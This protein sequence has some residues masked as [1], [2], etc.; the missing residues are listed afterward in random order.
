MESDTNTSSTIEEGA[1]EWPATGFES[2]GGSQGQGFDSFTLL[3]PS[4]D[5]GSRRLR[6]GEPNPLAGTKFQSA[7]VAQQV[8]RPVEAGK[9]VRSIRT[10]STKS[11]DRGVQRQHVSL[12]SLGC[13]FDSRRSLQVVRSS[14]AQLA[15]ATDRDSVQWEFESPR[16]YQ[17]DGGSNPPGRS[18]SSGSSSVSEASMT[19]YVP[20]VLG[21]Q[22]L[23]SPSSRVRF[24]VPVPVVSSEAKY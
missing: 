24:L 23:Q 18:Q 3:Q 22:G 11:S 8:E 21:R 9:G 16:S 5:V 15:E 10:R 4:P 20:G 12:P 2:R 1:A 19:Y 14:V 13:G 7:S 17:R 6:L